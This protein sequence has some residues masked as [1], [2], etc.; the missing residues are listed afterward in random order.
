ML[1]KGVVLTTEFIQ[2]YDSGLEKINGQFYEGCVVKLLGGR[3][4]KILS[5]VFDSQK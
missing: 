1:E 2:K 5:K 3:S 4:F